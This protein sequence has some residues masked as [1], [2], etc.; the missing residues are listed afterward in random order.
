[1]G[2]EAQLL[3][4]IADRLDL[5]RRSV[6]FHNNQHGLALEAPVYLGWKGWAI[7]EG[8]GSFCGKADFCGWFAR[9]VGACLVR[10]L[11]LA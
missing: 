1:M 7:S 4:V 10:R 8:M 6:R 2:P 9:E 5:F 11:V 3:N